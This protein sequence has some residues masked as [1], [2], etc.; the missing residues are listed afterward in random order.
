MTPVLQVEVVRG[1]RSCQR[2]RVS[3][4]ECDDEVLL[5]GMQ[6]YVHVYVLSGRLW[7]LGLMAVL[8]VF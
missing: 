4:S 6:G 1:L 3:S 7:G 5:V 8:L 2:S